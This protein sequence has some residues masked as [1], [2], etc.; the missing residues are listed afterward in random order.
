PSTT[1]GRASGGAAG[2]QSGSQEQHQ[3]L[4]PRSLKEDSTIKYT[5]EKGK[6]VT[7]NISTGTLAGY[8]TL[9]SSGKAVNVFKRVP[10]A[11]SPIGELR[12]QKPR[13]AKKWDGVWDATDLLAALEFVQK[14][15]QCFG[16]DPN[17]VAV[18]GHSSGAVAAAQ[19][20]FS[21]QIDPHS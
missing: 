16:G 13:P 8:Q 7:V 14:E 9:A 12:F 2:K 11:A 18:M 5:V 4:P 1:G 17:N 15:I 21:K 3:V 19:F 20:S 6:R 10:Y